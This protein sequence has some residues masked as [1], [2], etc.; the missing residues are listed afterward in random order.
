MPIATPDLARDRVH[1]QLCEH[2]VDQADPDP[3]QGH[4]RDDLEP[5]RVEACQAE[6]PSPGTAEPT[7]VSAFSPGPAGDDGRQAVVAGLR[8]LTKAIQVDDA[9][10]GRSSAASNAATVGASGESAEAPSGRM[11]SRMTP[12]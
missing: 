10:A 8:A 5:A 9:A 11:P 1:D 6:P 4:R 3:E 12:R 2:R 7:A